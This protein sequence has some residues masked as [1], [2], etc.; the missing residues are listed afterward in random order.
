MDGMALVIIN[1]A[2]GAGNVAAVCRAVETRFAAA[3]IPVDLHLTRHGEK[4]EETVARL[5]EN[6]T[7]LVVAAG[8]DGTVS[9][10]ANAATARDIPVA[11]IPTGTGNLFARELHIPL[12]V[13]EAAALAAEPPGIRRIDAMRIDGRLYLLNVGVG[14]T[15]LTVRDTLPEAKHLIGRAAYVLTALGKLLETEPVDIDVT[16][17]EETV[18]VR[19]P[20]VTI[21]NSGMLGRMILPTGPPT[22]ID[23]GVVD[24]SFFDTPTILHYPAA[25]AEALAGLFE[26]SHVRLLGAR[27]RV[28]IESDPSLPVQADGELVGRT[29][30][31]VEVLAGAVGI[32]AP[33]PGR[34]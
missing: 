12:A 6:D 18:H 13:E 11:I 1:P 34:P 5:I 27:R 30:V 21:S 4:I 24:V 22:S 28:R 8:G 17:D 33:A 7:T 19:S 32:V 15:S 10:A 14:I 25:A 23:D 20:E 3:G 31:D 2:A 26:R 29:P 16:V 9:G